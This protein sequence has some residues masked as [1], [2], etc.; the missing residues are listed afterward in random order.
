MQQ[1]HFWQHVPSKAKRGQYLHGLYGMILDYS[2]RL[3]AAGMQVTTRETEETSYVLICLAADGNTERH[4]RIDKLYNTENKYLT[5]YHFTRTTV[6]NHIEHKERGYF[7][8]SNELETAPKL[9]QLTCYST[10][11]VS[12]ETIR[13]EVIHFGIPTIKDLLGFRN[14]LIEKFTQ[15]LEQIEVRL[16]RFYTLSA[17]DWVDVASMTEIRDLLRREQEIYA[18]ISLYCNQHVESEQNL[19]LIHL[20]KIIEL[21]EVKLRSRQAYKDSAEEANQALSIDPVAISPAY[22][23]TKP[24]KKNNKKGNSPAPALNLS[25]LQTAFEELREQLAS[26]P[27]EENL[28]KLHEQLLLLEYDLETLTAAKNKSSNK[29]LQTIN[30]IHHQ[31][32]L[33]LAAIT[34][35]KTQRLAKIE[36][37][38]DAYAALLDKI[39]LNLGENRQIF[40]SE[41]TLAASLAEDGVLRNILEFAGHTHEA[42]LRFYG[43]KLDDSCLPPALQAK[44]T[45]LME[46]SA[47]ECILSLTQKYLP[48]WITTAVC[49]CSVETLKRLM[50]MYP[51][52]RKIME[53][54]S[55]P[56]DNLLQLYLPSLLAD[57]QTLRTPQGRAWR[58]SALEMLEFCF[59]TSANYREH[60][61]SRILVGF[62]PNDTKEWKI[63]HIKSIL[64]LLMQKKAWD[65]FDLVIKHGKHANGELITLAL[66]SLPMHE[67][68]QATL[69]EITAD[70]GNTLT[71]TLT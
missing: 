32:T 46:R 58:H 38:L 20:E 26:A 50:S 69:T 2:D 41:A 55:E 27:N 37:D 24:T 66:R 36:A 25:T 70:Q 30:T 23:L 43:L 62:H 12:D 16:S 71:L 57:H 15:E 33:K 1:L 45:A 44:K 3:A 40:S 5:P 29:T 59:A 4:I 11:G 22:S 14:T 47:A 61:L 39:A 6:L 10:H 63:A 34:L 52:T 8:L 53:Q 21:F 19:P 7:V 51:V 67:H 35:E 68:I 54:M 49:E 31:C 18:K 60:F 9:Q 48:H 42:Q 13:D 28:P 56:Y 65:I 64:K 17:T